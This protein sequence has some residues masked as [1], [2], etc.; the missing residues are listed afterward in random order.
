MNDFQ[1]QTL[2]TRLSTPDSLSAFW[3]GDYNTSTV[4]EISRGGGNKVIGNNVDVDTRT[5]T[6]SSVTFL[7]PYPHTQAR[8]RVVFQIQRAPPAYAPGPWS[9]WELAQ[10]I[11]TS[12]PNTTLTPSQVTLIPSSPPTGG[13]V[14]GTGTRTQGL[15]LVILLLPVAVLSIIVIVVVT[16]ILVLQYRKHQK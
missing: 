1:H 6:W 13:V 14:G 7:H 9:E 16:V 3:E 10:G 12:P 15:F 8:I 2:N 11:T 5:E 4:F